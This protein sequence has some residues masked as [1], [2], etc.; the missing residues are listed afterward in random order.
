MKY[1]YLPY[2]L[3]LYI[4]LTSCGPSDD[5]MDPE[6]VPDD[7][8]I[9]LSAPNTAL[10]DEVVTVDITTNQPMLVWPYHLIIFKPALPASQI[11][12][13]HKHAFLD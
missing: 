4:L 7:F 8:N 3:I 2:L 12:A 6:I 5:S 9:E 1:N 11:W 10:I 13:V